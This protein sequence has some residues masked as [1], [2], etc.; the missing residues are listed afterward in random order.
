[1]AAMTETGNGRDAGDGRHA[2]DEGRRQRRLLPGQRTHLRE[3]GQAPA[4]DGRSGAEE[5][6]RL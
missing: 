5:Q 2:D 1:M 3:P 4:V 6:Q